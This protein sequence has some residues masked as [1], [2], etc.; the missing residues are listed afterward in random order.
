MCFSMF[1]FKIFDL[2][3]EF[4]VCLPYSPFRLTRSLGTCVSTH[5]LNPTDSKVIMTCSLPRSSLS[6]ERWRCKRHSYKGIYISLPHFPFVRTPLVLRSGFSMDVLFL[7]QYL[8]YQTSTRSSWWLFMLW[9]IS[10]FQ[11]ERRAGAKPEGNLGG[12]TTWKFGV[13]G[14]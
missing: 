8:L 12:R 11:V 1:S 6:G 10:T 14:M 9:I 13:I 7:F 4:S 3:S 5:L 2:L